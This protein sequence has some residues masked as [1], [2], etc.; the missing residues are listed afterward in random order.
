M[1][2]NSAPT[3]RARVVI[4]AVMDEQYTLFFLSEQAH[5]EPLPHPASL[6]HISAH[7]GRALL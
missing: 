1:R 7:C 6:S 3:I 5:L 4:F 2:E